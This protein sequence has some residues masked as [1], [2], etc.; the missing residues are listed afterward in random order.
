[1]TEQS[2]PSFANEQFIDDYTPPN[3]LD[4]KAMSMLDSVASIEHIGS[5]KAALRV[6]PEVWAHLEGRLA[7]TIEDM[8]IAIGHLEADGRIDEQTAEGMRC[9]FGCKEYDQSF[10]VKNEQWAAVSRT[11]DSLKK[12]HQKSVPKSQQSA[13]FKRLIL[14]NREHKVEEGSSDDGPYLQKTIDDVVLRGTFSEKVKRDH[15][16]HKEVIQ[17]EP[18]EELA[19]VLILAE[20]RR[21]LE[22]YYPSQAAD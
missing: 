21:M 5:L 16:P 2:E 15:G 11:R 4:N 17:R 19:R 20:A 7:E 22:F 1:M 10:Y 13:I 18:S 3:E 8:E 6:E 14:T 9:L 12:R